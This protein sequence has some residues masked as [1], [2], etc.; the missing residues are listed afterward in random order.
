MLG[1]LPS[2]LRAWSSQPHRRTGAPKSGR[3]MPGPH[4]VRSGCAAAEA[5]QREL[6]GFSR[7]ARRGRH[8]C[9]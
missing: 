9:L 1:L 4:S 8:G 7:S 3:A 2:T 5:R 6:A